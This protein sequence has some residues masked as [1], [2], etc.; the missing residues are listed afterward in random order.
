MNGTDDGLWF[1]VMANE[2]DDW[3]IG[4]EDIEEAKEMLLEQ[5]RGLIAAINGSICMYK[6]YYEDIAPKGSYNPED[7]EFEIYLLARSIQKLALKLGRD[8][9]FSTLHHSYDDKVAVEV[10][11]FVDRN[12]KITE[13]EY[14]NKVRYEHV[15]VN[16]TDDLDKNIYAGI[17][18]R[19]ENLEQG[20]INSK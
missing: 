7:V 5:G 3:S 4:S 17:C 11:L 6:I 9:D 10:N 12:N 18:E 8:I 14:D 1:A 15:K 2:N 20:I 13:K 16:Y 19:V